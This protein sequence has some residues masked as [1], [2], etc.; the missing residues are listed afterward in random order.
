MAFEII[1][2][3]ST[4][5]GTCHELVR[6]VNLLEKPTAGS[7]FVDGQEITGLRGSE[8][9]AARQ[10]IGMVFQHF[11]LLYSRTVYDNIAFPLEIAG[12]PKSQIKARVTELLELVG[13]TERA[14]GLPG[15]TLRRPETTGGHC[16]GFG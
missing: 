1:F 13:L 6:C 5:G 9:R 4:E 15:P 16:P 2:A 12:V 8:L 14:K 11:N 10:K 3:F 7:V